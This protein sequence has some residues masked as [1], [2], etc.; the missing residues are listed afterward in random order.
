MQ[1]RAADMASIFQASAS[2]FKRHLASRF[3]LPVGLP[4]PGIDENPL[5]GAQMDGGAPLMD[6][7]EA[8]SCSACISRRAVLRGGAV[9]AVMMALPLGC[10]SSTP[11]PGPIPA[12]N[13]ADVRVD[14]LQVVPGEH[15]FLA[16]S[17]RADRDRLSRTSRLPSRKQ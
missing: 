16:G 9:G 14:S 13:V 12:G 7:A 8:D 15:V 2:E 1:S 4:E 17:N 6:Q 10:A 11:T 3:V 5:R